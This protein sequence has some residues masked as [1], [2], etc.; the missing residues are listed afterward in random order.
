MGGEYI[1]CSGFNRYEPPSPSTVGDE[2]LEDTFLKDVEKLHDILPQPFRRIDK[3]LTEI[4]DN[5]WHSIEQKHKENQSMLTNEFKVDKMIYEEELVI[6][7]KVIGIISTTEVAFLLCKSNLLVYCVSTLRLISSYQDINDSSYYEKLLLLESSSERTLLL[8]HYSNGKVQV[9]GYINEAFHVILEDIHAGNSLEDTIVENLCVSDDGYHVAISYSNNDKQWLT[10]YKLPIDEWKTQLVALSDMKSTNASQEEHEDISKEVIFSKVITIFKLFSPSLK[11]NSNNI[12]QILKSVDPDS[13][14]LTYGLNH[15]LSPTYFQKVKSE[16][17]NK[18]KRN[19]VDVLKRSKAI[20]TVHYLKG[21]TT[22]SLFPS[23]KKTKD[24]V[25]NAVAVWWTN[26]HQ[27]FLYHLKPGKDSDPAPFSVLPH[28]HHI[29]LSQV[30]SDTNLIATVL[31]N[32]SLSI[33]NRY[34]GHPLK[35]LSAPEQQCISF[36]KFS[37]VFHGAVQDCLTYGTSDGGLYQVVCGKFTTSEV[38]CLDRKS[39]P[40][41]ENDHTIKSV[42]SPKNMLTLVWPNGDIILYNEASKTPIRQLELFSTDVSIDSSS[43]NVAFASDKILA[44]RDE[45]NIGNKDASRLFLFTCDGEPSLQP[46]FNNSLFEAEEEETVDSLE[47]YFLQFLRQRNLSDDS[48]H[49]RISK[50]YEEVSQNNFIDV[51]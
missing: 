22:T 48:L 6:H 14:L 33:W 38:T 47:K 1:K 45:S 26:R 3:I 17:Q 24:N 16:V 21:Q 15:L 31:V 30:N 50:Q 34:T 42:S 27:M 7:E 39:V 10:M 49:A 29:K 43:I 51:N 46:F 35:V 40:K 25:H 44:V 28:A 11:A 4:Y 37:S 23:S 18:M 8:S 36:M 5:V 32:D 13:T 9:I 2:Y 19:E 41:C 20:A 12:S